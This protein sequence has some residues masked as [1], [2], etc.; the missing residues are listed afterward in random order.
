MSRTLSNRII[1]LILWVVICFA[2]AAIGAF[3]SVSAGEFYDQLIRPDWAPPG[4]LFG[5]VWT[6]LYLL[7]AMA[8]WLVW[9]NVGKR[10]AKF[11]LGIFLLQ[12]VFNALWP[13]LF[14][15]WNLG[16]WAFAEILL[17][18][19]LILVTLLLFWKTRPLAGVLLTPYLLWVSF[20]SALSWSIWQLN[21]TLLAG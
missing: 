18:W 11:S 10:G 17:L 6:I 4:W 14:F 19:T 9:L 15:V 21:P 16:F 8:A 1:G 13:W 5:P 12:L 2:A 3:A 20:A 7:M